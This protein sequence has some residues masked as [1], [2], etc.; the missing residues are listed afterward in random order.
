MLTF[1]DL[2]EA[3]CHQK[4][5]PGDIIT[6]LSK[7]C[8]QYN[9][10][11]LDFDDADT[12]IV[13]GDWVSGTTTTAAISKVVEVHADTTSWTNNTGYLILDS[14]TGTQYVDNEELTVAAGAAMANVNGI[15]KFHTGYP[16]EGVLAKAA[17]VVVYA[18]TA[19]VDW[20]GGKP[21]QTALIGTPMVANSSVL[22]RNYHDIANFKCVDYTSGS[23]SIVQ[24]KFFF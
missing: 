11:R 2:G 12:E 23:A 7:Y 24:V 9:R 15:L 21:N 8:Y 22:L 16:N 20:T 4:I 3:L 1:E 17:L 5:T 13:V 18:N 14:W 19:L 10:Y 6:S